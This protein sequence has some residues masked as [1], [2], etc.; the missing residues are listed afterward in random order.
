MT[1]LSHP[2]DSIAYRRDTSASMFT[3]ASFT[4][5]SDGTGL[6]IHL[7]MLDN[8]N[9]VNTYNGTSFTCQEKWS[10]IF[11]FALPF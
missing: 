1:R 7:Q 11:F 3:N 6:D 8:E 9:A 5:G 4:M 2:R 10:F